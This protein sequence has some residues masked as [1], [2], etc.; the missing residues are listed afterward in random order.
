MDRVF[1]LKNP[2]ENMNSLENATIKAIAFIDGNNNNKFDK[3]E[4]PV[5]DVLVEFGNRSVVTDEN[6][7]AY[8]Y[9]I[10]SY[11]D[12][13][14][15]I[16]SERPSFKTDSNIIKVRGIG[17]SEIEAYIPVKPMIFFTG[18]LDIKEVNDREKDLILSNLEIIVTNEE[19]KFYKIFSPDY[20]GQFY[21]YDITPGIYDISI[22]YNGEDFKLKNYWAKLELKYTEENHGDIEYNFVLEEE[23][24]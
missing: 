4:L 3:E 6:G 21:L 2:K 14:L 13:E 20:E 8:I 19:Q 9:G 18:T 7:I 16:S 1:N 5:S 23:N 11:I 17:S 15:K 22:N 12:Y 10:P 24:N